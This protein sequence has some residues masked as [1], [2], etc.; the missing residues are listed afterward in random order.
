MHSSSSTNLSNCIAKLLMLDSRLDN[1]DF[2]PQEELLGMCVSGSLVIASL[3]E[4][5]ITTQ[6]TNDEIEFVQNLTERIETELAEM[7]G[8]PLDGDHHE[9]SENDNDDHWDS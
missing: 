7:Y 8:I 5:T 4:T 6:F 2:T 9:D 3:A 1:A